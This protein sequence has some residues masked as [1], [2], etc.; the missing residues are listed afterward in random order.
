VGRIAQY[1][2]RKG[3]WREGRP[4]QDSAFIRFSD[5][6]GIRNDNV[7][8][9]RAIAAFLL[10]TD[11]KA[12][13]FY[14]VNTQRL[15][16]VA[17][18]RQAAGRDRPFAEVGTPHDMESQ[19]AIAAPRSPADSPAAPPADPTVDR[20][21]DAFKTLQTLVNRTPSI[22]NDAESLGIQPTDDWETIH[23][24]YRRRAR[25]THPDRGGSPAEFAALHDAYLRLK[26]IRLRGW[27]DDH[28]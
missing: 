7:A 18:L 1:W 2:P 11:P 23:R 9:E 4:P 10:R 20:V 12:K 16:T 17:E 14:F 26:A 6:S 13:H 3:D 28:A 19:P 22:A 25:E 24:A 21:L 27:G 15:I 8:T 5:R